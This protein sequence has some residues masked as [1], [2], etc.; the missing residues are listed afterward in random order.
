VPWGGERQRERQ[1]EKKAV[2][3]NQPKRNEKLVGA[4]SSKDDSGLRIHAGR[5]LV[6]N[7]RVL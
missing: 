5:T 4:S 2:G 1:R 6:G 3:Y 7:E